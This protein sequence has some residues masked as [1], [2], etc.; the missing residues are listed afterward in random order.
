MNL[1][2]KDYFFNINIIKL[3]MDYF[4]SLFH[5]TFNNIKLYLINILEDKFFKI[6]ITHMISS[7]NSDF[8]MG[9]NI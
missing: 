8:K 7:E 9:P 2:G 5:F 4:Y 6:Q 3:Y 1:F